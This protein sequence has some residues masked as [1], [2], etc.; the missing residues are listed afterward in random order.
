MPLRFFVVTEQMEGCYC[1]FLPPL[2]PFP[3][4][5]P[6]ALPPLFPLLPL[7][8]NVAATATPLPFVFTLI[9]LAT[10]SKPVQFRPFTP[11]EATN[12]CAR[13]VKS[14]LAAAGS[15]EGRCCVIGLS[16]CIRAGA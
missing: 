14:E 8:L 12:R 10:L 11:K 2:P 9:G 5:P 15:G 4:L 7:V 6:L 16:S 1:C 3:P 13:N